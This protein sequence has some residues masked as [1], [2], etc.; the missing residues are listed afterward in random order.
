MTLI[1]FE[2]KSINSITFVAFSTLMTLST[3]WHSCRTQITITFIFI[4]ISTNLAVT[5]IIIRLF[6]KSVC[7]RTSIALLITRT[8]STSYDDTFLA[9]IILLIKSFHTLAYFSL[10]IYLPLSISITFI[11]R[12]R[13][14]T[15]LTFLI[16]VAF[17][18]KLTLRILEEKLNT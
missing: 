13:I 6:N 15:L 3:A 16:L 17:L 12:F 18:A 5:C 10:V 9:C 7:S 1:T 11:T 8:F 4:Q 14:L 2:L